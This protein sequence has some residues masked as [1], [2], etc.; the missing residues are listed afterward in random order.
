MVEVLMG[1]ERYSGGEGGNGGD[2]V[3]SGGN[4]VSN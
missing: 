4:S 1:T 3:S 2:E